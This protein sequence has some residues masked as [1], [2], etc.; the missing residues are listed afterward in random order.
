MHAR[1]A[2]EPGELTLGIATRG[3][4]DSSARG[5][6]SD[7]A[8]QYLAKLTI[9]DEVKGL[10]ILRHAGVQKRAHFIEP[11]VG[12]HSVGARVN[13][14]IQGFAFRSEPDLKRVPTLQG[15]APF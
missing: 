15:F 12:K 11:S 6:Q 10:G 7:F 8:V 14:L 1:L 13:P 5:V 9:T 4:M 3:L 2:P